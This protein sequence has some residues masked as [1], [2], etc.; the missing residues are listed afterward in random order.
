[1]NFLQELEF[2]INKHC[3]ENESDTP[4]YILARYI[5]RCLDNWNE[6]TYE[7]DKWWG[8]KKWTHEAVESDTVLRPNDV[9]PEQDRTDDPVPR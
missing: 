2:V 5:G 8:F 9:V 1:M 7:R 6:T 4:D 3:V